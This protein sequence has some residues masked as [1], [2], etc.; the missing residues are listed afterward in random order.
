M[1]K[2]LKEARIHAQAT[3]QLEDSMG[4]GYQ[5][6]KR[7]ESAFLAGAAHN[8]ERLLAK[9][10]ERLDDIAE[11]FAEEHCKDLGYDECD[12][13]ETYDAVK[14]G[15]KCGTLLSMARIEQLEK[16]LRECDLNY[17]IESSFLESTIQH[18]TSHSPSDKALARISLKVRKALGGYIE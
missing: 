17:K 16:A 14:H 18:S 7:I 1:D 6:E 11:K 9:A 12:G 13:H 5:I 15:V 10:G 8:Q 4:T 3:Q 2:G